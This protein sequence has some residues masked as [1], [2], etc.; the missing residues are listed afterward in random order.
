MV[1]SRDKGARL[2]REAAHA[3]R[4]ELGVPAERS[5]RNGVPGAADVIGLPGVRFEVKGRRSIGALR[6]MDQARAEAEDYEI[7]V[8]LMRENGGDWH[9][10]MALSDVLGLLE[11][12]P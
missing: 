5:A 12:L 8:V 2:E 7:P 10:M 1:N 4:S 6:F 11:R 3:L 9:L